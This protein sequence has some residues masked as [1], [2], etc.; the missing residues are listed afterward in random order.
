MPSFGKE[1]KCQVKPVF[2]HFVDRAPGSLLEEKEHSLV[3]HYRMAEPELGA[4]LASELVPKLEAVL[5]EPGLGVFRGAKIVEVRPAQAN[6]GRVLEYLRRNLPQPDFTLA[7]GDDRTDEDLFE[8]MLDGWTVHV[9][10]GDT[11]A[12]FVLP[13]VES[14]RRMLAVFA[15]VEQ[16]GSGN[17]PQAYPQKSAAGEFR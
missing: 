11:R 10:P 2:E 17:Q 14:A 4:T 8:R 9:G 15:E 7:V 1:W 5:R 16:F 6:K 13:D 3:W 12:E